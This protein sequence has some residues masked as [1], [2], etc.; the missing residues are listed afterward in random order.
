GV[1][2]LRRRISYV[3]LLPH[4]GVSACE[5]NCRA[6]CRYPAMNVE[7]VPLQPQIADRSKDTTNESKMKM[8]IYFHASSSN[9][10]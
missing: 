5:R 3:S 9:Y 6:T 4:N 1:Q 2:R 7:D 8:K 10:R